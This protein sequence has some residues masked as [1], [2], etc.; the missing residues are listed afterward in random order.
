MKNDL[1]VS[2][3]FGGEFDLALNPSDQVVLKVHRSD[4]CVLPGNCVVHHPSEHR[5]RGFPL[6]WRHDKGIFERTC[7]HG[8]GHDD[9]DDVAYQRYVAGPEDADWTGVHGC[10]GCCG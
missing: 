10:D 4:K 3:A 7:P 8:I 1:I 9:P 2:I 5:M 6:H